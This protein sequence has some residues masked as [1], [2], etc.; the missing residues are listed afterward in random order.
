M[1]YMADDLCLTA[2]MLQTRDSRK[3]SRVFCFSGR[4]GDAV[5]HD[6]R[7]RVGSGAGCSAVGIERA[8]REDDRGRGF[9]RS[10]RGRLI[11]GRD[12]IQVGIR[13]GFDRRPHRTALSGAGQPQVRLDQE[14]GFHMIDDVED[15]A[16]RP[17][18]PR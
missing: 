15:H 4:Q 13:A 14:L 9:D 8:G 7:R 2:Q 10:A 18:R 11:D 3:A 5:L 12:G 1:L 17:A 6:R 16:A